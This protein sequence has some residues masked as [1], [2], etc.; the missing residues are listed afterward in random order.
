MRADADWIDPRVPENLLFLDVYPSNQPASFTLYEDDGETTE[1]QSGRFAGTVLQAHREQGGDVALS[2][3]ES[4][5]DYTGKPAN[6]SFEITVQLTDKAPASVSK[7][8]LP[9][10]NLQTAQALQAS[11][12]GWLYNEQ[13]HTVI[14]KV[15][16]LSQSPLKVVISSANKIRR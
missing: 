1:Y 9:V 8:G 7:N 2:I 3:G 14:V 15:T 4:H 6:R 5:G 10:V 11:S 12:E 16:Q 13:G